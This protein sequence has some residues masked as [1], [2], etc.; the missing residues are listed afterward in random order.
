MARRQHT[1]PPLVLPHL[2]SSVAA[3]RPTTRDL[4]TTIHPNLPST[5]EDW[6]HAQD[7]DPAFLQTLDP[8]L[9][10]NCNGLTIYKDADFNSRILVPPSLR[11]QLIRQHHHDLQHV[12][13]P[14]V[15]TSLSRHYFWPKM[16]TDVRRV[17]ED[18]ELCEN[19][20]G[21]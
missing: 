15:F 14:K 6:K 20:K 10:A 7:N 18:C 16:K 4:P 2:L 8:D 19:E 12:S 21:K 11:D 1:P 13:H 3:P 17:V 9:L 5:L